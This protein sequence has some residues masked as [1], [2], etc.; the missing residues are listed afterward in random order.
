MD[1]RNV[2]LEE[3]REELPATRKASATHTRGQTRVEAAR[4][5]DDAGRAGHAHCDDPGQHGTDHPR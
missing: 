1:I 4:E 2:M 3:F 5:V